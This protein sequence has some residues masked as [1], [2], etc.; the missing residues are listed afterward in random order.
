MSMPSDFH[1]RTK[2]PVGILGATG[3]V[4]QRFVHLLENH[5]WFELVAVAASD[6]SVGKTYREAVKWTIPGE[7]SDS[8]GKMEVLPCLP[9]KMQCKVVFTALDSTVAGEIEETF[10]KAGFLVLS[11]AKNHRDGPLVPLLIPEVNHDH[12]GLLAKQ[13]YGKGKIVTNPNCAAVGLCMALKPLLELSEIESVHVVTMQSISGAGYPGV[14]SMDIMDNIIPYI[15]DEEPKLESEPC[16]I[17]GSLRGDAIEPLAIKISAQCN[18]VPVTV[19][20]MEAVSVKFKGSVEPAGM[21]DAWTTF[22]EQ[23]ESLQL[24]SMPQRPIHYFTEKDYPQ[25]RLHR[26][27]DQGMGV[28]IGRLRSCPLLDYKFIVLS[29][30]MI[31]GA[32]GGA[33]LNAELMVKMGYVFW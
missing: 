7:L 2:I 12:L 13:P 28:S 22:G 9:D 21:I 3:A 14:P 27:L 26:F 24:P 23:L 8:I 32:A 29:N 31:R 6:R 5:P 30:N 10:A 4:G 18:R 1:F 17:L 33:I 11:N 16:K 20:H 15:N 19:G 25:P